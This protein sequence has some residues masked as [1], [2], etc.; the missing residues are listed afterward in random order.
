[1]TTQVFPHLHLHFQNGVPALSFQA[2]FMACSL[3]NF[4]PVKFC[5]RFIQVNRRH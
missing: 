4:F 3:P 2:T 1:M 5:P